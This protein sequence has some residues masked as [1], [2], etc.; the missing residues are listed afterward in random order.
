[1]AVAARRSRRSG[2]ARC[3]ICRGASTRRSRNRPRP[4]LL[5]PV[6]QRPGLVDGAGTVEKK[7]EP[8]CVSNVGSAAAASTNRS[9]FN[10]SASSIKTVTTLQI[11]VRRHNSIVLR[12]QR[13]PLPGA[14][15]L[16]DVKRLPKPCGRS[17]ITMLRVVRYLVILLLDVVLATHNPRGIRFTCTNEPTP[18]LVTS[19]AH[20]LALAGGS[21]FAD[22]IHARRR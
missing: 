14:W 12:N 8:L 15:L 22:R 6:R 9:A 18:R 3:G 19:E 10:R 11:P 7:A 4:P 2:T 5:D 13:V 16:N 1:M 21:G 17:G 20:L